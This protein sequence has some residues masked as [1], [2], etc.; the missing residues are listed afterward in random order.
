MR[1]TYR[2]GITMTSPLDPPS[3]TDNTTVALGSGRTQAT[4]TFCILLLSLSALLQSEQFLDFSL[5]VSISIDSRR[6]QVTCVVECP[7]VLVCLTS[8]LIQFARVFGRNITEVI[9]QSSRLPYQ[10]AYNFSLSHCCLLLAVWPW[11][12]SLPTLCLSSLVCKRV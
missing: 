6:R 12:S 2:K 11:T 9:T 3:L 10:V 8:P 4:I 5:A 7:S 1:K